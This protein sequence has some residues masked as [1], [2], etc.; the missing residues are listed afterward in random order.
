LRKLVNGKSTEGMNFQI[1]NR[2]LAG[3]LFLL[4]AVL[5]GLMFGFFEVADYLRYV[6]LIKSE[7]KLASL[8]VDDL[9]TNIHSYKIG[10]DSSNQRFI[11]ITGV[12]DSVKQKTALQEF[13]AQNKNIFPSRVILNV[14]IVTNLPN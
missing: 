1:K 8:A 12:E 5:V 9:D 13:F 7:Q 6:R 10:L 14:T 2:N 11:S 3:K 4:L